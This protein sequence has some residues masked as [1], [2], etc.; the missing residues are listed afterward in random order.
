MADVVRP[1]G[2]GRGGAQAGTG[3]VAGPDTG[4]GVEA[5]TVRVPERLAA[6]PDDPPAAGV[7]ETAGPVTETGSV[8]TDP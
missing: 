5:G 1:A 7:N 4:T 6:R 3:T 2:L 8:V